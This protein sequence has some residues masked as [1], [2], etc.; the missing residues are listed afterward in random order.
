MINS[1][2]QALPATMAPVPTRTMPL[3]AATAMT[4]FCALGYSIGALAVSVM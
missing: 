3:R 2:T 1:Q 4:L